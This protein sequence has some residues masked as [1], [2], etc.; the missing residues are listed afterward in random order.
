MHMAFLKKLKDKLTPPKATISLTLNKSSFALG[1]NVEGTLSVSSD[2]EFD[3]TEVRCEIQCVEEAK[4]TKR[5]YDEALRREIE[6]QVMESATLY[7]AKP[8]ISGP[9]HLTKGF[10]QTF[11]FSINI[12]IG[13]R[14]TYKSIDSKVTW[15]MK[16]VIA[17]DG[18]PDVTSSTLEIQVTQPSATPVIKEKE[19][20]RE[21]VMIPCKYCGTLTPQT[22]IECPNCG[23][24]RTA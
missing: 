14:P 7:S 2:E 9:L 20:I 24:K 21:V 23:A 15:F 4:K 18:R 3:A 5:V 22:S 1:E 8:K 16:G 10:A 12:P 6:R 19:I 11:P 13:G 17:V